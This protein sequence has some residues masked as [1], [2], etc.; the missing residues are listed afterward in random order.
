MCGAA[1]RVR[2]EQG[3]PL[4]APLSVLMEKIRKER[5]RTADEFTALPASTLQLLA[6]LNE[7]ICLLG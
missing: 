3:R 7:S 5:G 4:S 6:Y 1:G 2:G